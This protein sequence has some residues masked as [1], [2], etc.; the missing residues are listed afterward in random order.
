MRKF[1]GS[2]ALA[3]TALLAGAGAAQAAPAH[4]QTA[5]IQAAPVTFTAD[6]LSSSEL[7]TTYPL[8]AGQVFHEA[9]TTGGEDFTVTQVIATGA[10]IT[11]V[12]ITPQ[13]LPKGT[14]EICSLGQ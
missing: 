6:D 5:H 9:G 3:A 11:Y 12:S 4:T 7:S 10:G 8:T 1:L 14:F 13:L 2:L